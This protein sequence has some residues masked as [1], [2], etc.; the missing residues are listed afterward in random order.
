MTKDKQKKHSYETYLQAKGL[1]S[2]AKEAQC[3]ADRYRTAL[4][5]LLD[6]EECGGHI[7]D[8]VYGDTEFELA[9]KLEGVEF[10]EEPA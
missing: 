2:L 9:L 6:K 1:F 10:K 4:L 5:R 7:D 8:A 3:E